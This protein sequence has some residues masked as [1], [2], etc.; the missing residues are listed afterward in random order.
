MKVT[1]RDLL[2]LKLTDEVIPEPL[3]GAHRYPDETAQNI[4]EA[5]GRH[6]QELSQISIPELI[7]HGAEGIIE[8]PLNKII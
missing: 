8:Y 3:G 5:L 7:K 4:R 6:L 2:D 1:A